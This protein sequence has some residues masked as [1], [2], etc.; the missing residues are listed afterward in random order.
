MVMT[1][2]VIQIENG[3]VFCKM[4]SFVYKKTP[5][6]NSFLTFGC[7]QRVQKVK[8]NKITQKTQNRKFVSYCFS[9]IYGSIDSKMYFWTAMF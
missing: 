8:K 4:T 6:T 1:T 7:D 9:K 5:Q 3:A 2:T